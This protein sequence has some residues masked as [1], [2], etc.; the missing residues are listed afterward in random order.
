MPERVA[1]AVLNEGSYSDDPWVV[2]YLGGVLASSRSDRPRDDRGVYWTQLISRLSA[3][4]LRA[5]YIW[6]NA[7]RAV[8]LQRVR[9]SGVNIHDAAQL[10]RLAVIMPSRVWGTAMD[11]VPE[12]LESFAELLTHCLHTLAAEGLLIW[13]AAGRAEDF[14]E[15]GYPGA[16]EAA[17]VYK[18]T[19][20][21]IQLS[22]W[23]AG[24]GDEPA[25]AFFG[26]TELFPRVELEI[27]PGSFADTPDNPWR[28]S[29][30]IAGAPS[31]E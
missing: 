9:D 30:T 31:A 7:F 28:A 29:P 18:P 16:S 14:R 11:F 8:Y 10:E 23:G 21:G 2:E 1:L 27:L 26:D 15:R 17:I 13:V 6:Y 5:H 12:E 25:T 3:Y 24:I 19:L 4:D 22:L 20:R